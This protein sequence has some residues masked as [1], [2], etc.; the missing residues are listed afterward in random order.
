MLMT[1]LGRFLF[2]ILFG[3]PGIFLVWA[4]WRAIQKRQRWLSLGVLV[5][6]EVVALKEYPRAASKVGRRIPIAPVVEYRL[7]TGTGVKRFTSREA[8]VPNPFAV[9]QQVEVRY[10]AGE[11]PEA[12]LNAVV[13]GW[14]MIA[15][16]AALALACLTAAMTPIIITVNEVMNR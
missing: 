6:G 2:S 4:T 5:D 12:E 11:S 8:V 1:Y 9:G 3:A 15:A 13:T 14:T 10:L 7:P 16:I